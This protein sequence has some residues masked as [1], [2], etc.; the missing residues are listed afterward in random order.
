MRAALLT[1]LV[2]PPLFWGGN[3]IV[4]RMAVGVVP[5]LTLNLLRWIVA[6]LILLPFAWRACLA[7]KA[8]LR[9][10]LG[11]LCLTALLSVASYN[12][13]QYL[14][15]TTSSPLNTSLI[16]A[17]T[18]VWI[19]LTGFVLFRVP[20]GGLSVLGAA[21]SLLGVGTILVRGNPGNL[22]LLQ[23]VPGDLYMLAGTFMWSL[24][25][26]LLLRRQ[27]GLPGHAALAAQMFLGIL[28]ALP[29]AAL[30][31][32]Y[33]GYAPV[34]WEWRTAGIIAYVGLFPSLLAYVCW[35]RAVAQAGAQLPVFFM[36]LAPIFTLLLSMLLLGEPPQG[37]HVVALA[38]ILLGI[39]LAQRQSAR[40]AAN[41]VSARGSG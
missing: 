29:M 4:G 15:L 39:W 37:Y 24:Y 23:F 14:A 34:V 6:L 21:L 26:W 3:A 10:H 31:L 2:A 38:L 36:N 17:S 8:L 25:T 22:A 7:H 18:P 16:G 5:P 19:L 30:E 1:V 20:V 28:F 35:Q 9:Q 33:G 27:T 32:R 41:A 40:G 12:A 11:F 13:L